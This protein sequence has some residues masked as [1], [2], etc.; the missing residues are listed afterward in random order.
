MRRDSC[1]PSAS[2]CAVLVLSSGCGL[3]G[4]SAPRRAAPP[5]EHEGA[6]TLT[7]ENDSFTGSDNNYTNRIGLWWSTD[8]VGTYG[9]GS[10][11]RRWT[12]FWSFLPFV[13]DESCLTYA[14]WAVGQEMHTPDDITAPDPPGRMPEWSIS[15]VSS[16]RAVMIG[17]TDGAYA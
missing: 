6:L 13:L 7:I 15:T 10:L 4:C 2:F 8:E 5:F 17:S 11:V 12:D 14:S 9:E 3:L 1:E 16:P